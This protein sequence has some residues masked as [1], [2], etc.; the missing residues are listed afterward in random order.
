MAAIFAYPTAASSLGDVPALGGV[1]VDISAADFTPPSGS[2]R[3]LYVGGTGD[4][5]VKG[6]DGNSYT[7]KAVPVGTTLS[8]AGLA[9]VKVGTTATLMVALL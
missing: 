3:A 5:V 6:L 4:V 1:A 7:L 8:V 2:F 9:V